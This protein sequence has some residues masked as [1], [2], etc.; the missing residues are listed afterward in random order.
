[1]RSCRAGSTVR[2]LAAPGAA[3]G[4]APAADERRDVARGRRRECLRAEPFRSPES[5]S[6]R[7][8][9]RRRILIRMNGSVAPTTSGLN[10]PLKKALTHG[11]A[12]ALDFRLALLPAAHAPVRPFRS[13]AVLVVAAA[14]VAR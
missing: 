6:A 13:P 1:D 4:R 12:L 5:D 11:P 9:A 10:E 8:I 3:L 7:R 2:L 14:A